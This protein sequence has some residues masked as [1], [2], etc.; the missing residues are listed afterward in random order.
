MRRLAGVAV[1]TAL[2]IGAANRPQAQASIVV[3]ITSYVTSAGI[4]T[5]TVTTLSGATAGVT[6][7]TSTAGVE[8]LSYTTPGTSTNDPFA[9]NFRLGLTFTSNL[10]ASNGAAAGTVVPTLTSTDYAQNSTGSTTRTIIIEASD[11]GFT[12]PGAAAYPSVVSRIGTNSFNST[13]AGAGTS[14][15]MGEADPSQAPYGSAVMTT[16]YTSSS[17]SVPTLP[18]T[19]RSPGFIDTTGYSLTSYTTATLT[20]GTSFSLGA[21]TS[22][23]AT[24][25]PGTLALALAGMPVL[26][27]MMARRRSVRAGR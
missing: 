16:P 23:V 20:G 9:P 10:T 19:V 4:G 12:Y 27:V 17:G 11:G 5:A 6:D 2:L 18:A 8:T 24:P 14:S 15:F 22:V 26:G 3:R 7:S 1:A 13:T 21:T 25:E